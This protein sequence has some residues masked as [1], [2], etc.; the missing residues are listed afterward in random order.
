[1]TVNSKFVYSNVDVLTVILCMFISP[2][3]STFSVP[4]T[5]AL[6][7]WL[8]LSL[9]MFDHL[10]LALPFMSSALR[11]L[12]EPHGGQTNPEMTSRSSRK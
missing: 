7:V 11:F 4:K 8:S 10:S 6:H 9:G 5:S 12:L 1:M 3:P 2:L